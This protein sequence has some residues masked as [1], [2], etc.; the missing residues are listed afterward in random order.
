MCANQN[1]ERE[2]R[3]ELQEWLLLRKIVGSFNQTSQAKIS[4]P[5]S[6]EGVS[7]D[8][9]E[10]AYL[11]S[12]KIFGIE[13]FECTSSCEPTTMNA[14]FR[15]TGDGYLENFQSPLGNVAFIKT[16][17]TPTTSHPMNVS[18]WLTALRRLSFKDILCPQVDWTTV[19]TRISNERLECGP[20]SS[21]LQ[22]GEHRWRENKMCDALDLIKS[23]T[24][25]K[26]LKSSF[27][28]CIHAMQEGEQAQLWVGITDA[29]N[30][31]VGINGGT[32]NRNDLINRFKVAVSDFFASV[33]P[34]VPVNCVEIVIYET[35][36][37]VLPKDQSR[38]DLAHQRPR[39]ALII[40]TWSSRELSL[41]VAKFL[42]EKSWH[43]QTLMFTWMHDRLYRQHLTTTLLPLRL[44]DVVILV[45]GDDPS[46][47]EALPVITHLVDRIPPPSP[48]LQRDQLLDHLRQ[49]VHGQQ[50]FSWEL[51]DAKMIPFTETIT[52]I[53]KLLRVRRVDNFHILKRYSGS[54]ASSALLSV[55]WVLERSGEA[56][57]FIVKAS[58][59][60][61]FWRVVCAEVQPETWIVLL[62]DDNIDAFDNGAQSLLNES[63]SHPYTITTLR[64]KLRGKCP[65]AL[66]PFISQEFLAQFC[67]QI[68]EA[69]PSEATRDVLKSLLDYSN[70][71]PNE[72]EHR[73]IY[74]IMHTATN[75]TFIP[76][77]TFFQLKIEKMC[78]FD[79]KVIL[80]LAF[81]S[82][83]SNQFRE[84]KV[85]SVDFHKLSKDALELTC[86]RQ[87]HKKI[88]FLH[89]SLA[90]LYLTI[91]CQYS[92][93]LTPS[94]KDQLLLGLSNFWEM[95][96]DVVRMS[97]SQFDHLYRSI[98][99]HAEQEAWTVL[100]ELVCTNESTEQEVDEIFLSPP[101]LQ[102]CGGFA[103]IA[104][105]RVHRR[106]S[107]PDRAL[108]LA[109]EA[110]QNLER[111][112]CHRNL[113]RSNFAETLESCALSS[114]N[115]ILV[116]AMRT[117]FID[118]SA[119]SRRRN[120]S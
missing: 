25:R 107:H 101:V 21:S 1:V 13:N 66:S 63:K 93:Q 83:T 106:L 119:M 17:G 53:L 111:D 114:G 51:L 45:Y 115:Q 85:G 18:L 100:Q 70:L 109:H 65:V 48:L 84:M 11:L 14:N 87:Q 62:V 88:T 118:I 22:P 76:P 20:T 108:V 28:P 77:R 117:Y 71:H 30:A 33:F 16:P 73:L 91:A 3:K 110:Y 26:Y 112:P 19:R 104:C 52:D 61:D 31:V 78:N 95:I 32:Q 6:F 68:C 41:R 36:G 99:I 55:G 120:M 102:H 12:K 90:D 46:G 58:L 96:A 89:P 4:V 15:L 86:W 37:S 103:K 24:I 69:I 113:A 7:Y 8:E 105:S 67:G 72:K 50:P 81:L 40:T 54:G 10:V 79:R 43:Y 27:L 56:K 49:W 82:L 116:D 98:F 9:K 39:E 92:G 59:T 57:V 60:A 94:P 34:P 29:N 74:A 35:A 47:Q 80:F 75:G 23:E 64:I 44:Q 97:S 5:C 2:K 38:L 42:D